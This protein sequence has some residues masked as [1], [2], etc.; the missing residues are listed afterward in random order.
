MLQATQSRIVEGPALVV[1]EDPA[2]KIMVDGHQINMG[3]G[4]STI[5]EY[6]LDRNEQ[7]LSAQARTSNSFTAGSRYSSSRRQAFFLKNVRTAPKPEN[8]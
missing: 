5:N 4:N 1:K 7:Q 8:G 3:P 6:G 2:V